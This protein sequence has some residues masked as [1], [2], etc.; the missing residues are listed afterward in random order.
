MNGPG[1][2][3]TDGSLSS[4]STHDQGTRGRVCWE[5][6]LL[7]GIDLC[8]QI[9]PP[10]DKSCSFFPGLQWQVLVCKTNVAIFFIL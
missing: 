9:P 3:Q 4:K 1:L 2:E 6:S 10:Q 8:M 7:A 5:L